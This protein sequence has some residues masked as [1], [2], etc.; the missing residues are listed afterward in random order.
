MGVVRFLLPRQNMT[1]NLIAKTMEV[2]RTVDIRL[3]FLPK[4]NQVV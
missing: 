4:I 2:Y 1:P 3:F